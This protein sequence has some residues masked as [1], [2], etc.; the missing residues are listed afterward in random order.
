MWSFC[1]QAKDEDSGNNGV[2]TFSIQQENFVYKDGAIATFQ[3]S[4]RVSTSSEANVFT[5]SIE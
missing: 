2:I 4:F 5:G 1:S 3:G